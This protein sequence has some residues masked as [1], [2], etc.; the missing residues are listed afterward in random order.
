VGYPRRLLNEDEDVVFDLHP[1]WK[2]LV[3]PSLLAPVIVFAATFGAGKV[4]EGSA[5][6]KLRLLV[7]V[8]AV[9][10][11]V[12]FVARPYVV[13]LT[14]HFVLTTRRVLMREGLIARKGRDIPIFRINDVTFEHTVVE[15][16][17][18][19]GT[20]IVE[21]AGE[22][23]QVTLTDI[24]HVEDVQREIYTLMDADDAR[25]RGGAGQVPDPES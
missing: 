10:A 18:G 4:P 19:A 15:R 1:H 22:R 20:L 21:S 2:G 3:V 8:L 12:W 7:A 9:V 14:T 16:M 6:G 25:R 11:L 24:P 23:G 13:W 5:Q 17:F